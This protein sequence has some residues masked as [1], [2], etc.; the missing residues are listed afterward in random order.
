MGY[1]LAAFLQPGY[2]QKIISSY[3]AR[4]IGGGNSEPVFAH[5]MLESA[6]KLVPF[7]LTAAT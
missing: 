4:S 7:G 2:N 5:A 1:S 3:G 6:M